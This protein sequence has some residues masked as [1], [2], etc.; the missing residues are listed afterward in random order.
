MSEELI[1]TISHY[2]AKPEVGVVTLTADI[3]V[4]DTLRFSGHG[5]DFQQ[6]VTSMELDHVHVD[7]ASA[8]TE[9][10]MKVEQRVREGTHVYRIMP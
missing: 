4:G 6:A 5:V 7:T 10:A 3:K 2:F 9:V 1:G 8:G